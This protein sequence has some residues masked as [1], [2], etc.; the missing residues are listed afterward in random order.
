MPT[1]HVS[2]WVALHNSDPT[3]SGEENEVNAAG[4]SRVETTANGDWT[5]TG[6]TFENAVDIEFDVAEENWGEVTHFSLWDG[7]ADTDNAIASSTLDASRTIEDGD[8]AVFRAGGLT[9]DVN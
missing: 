8:Q 1:A 7:S 9:G 6:D 4:Y 3:N 5:R 2:V